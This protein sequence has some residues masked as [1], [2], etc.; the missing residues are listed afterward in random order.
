[1]GGS[2]RAGGGGSVTGSFMKIVGGGWL[3][4]EAAGGG[5]H[6]CREDVRKEEGGGQNIFFSGPKVPPGKNCLR[7]RV[8]HDFWTF[9]DICSTFYHG[10]MY[11][12]LSAPKSQRFSRF[13]IAMPIADPRNCSDFRDK[14]KQCCI[15]I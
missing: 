6:R 10:S 15:A 11:L 12:G 14:G 8:W 5:E 2:V 7:R 9:F 4:E 13:S 3:S 1:M